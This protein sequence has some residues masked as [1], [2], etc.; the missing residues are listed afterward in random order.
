M[1]PLDIVYLTGLL[2]TMRQPNRSGAKTNSAYGANQVPIEQYL[3]PLPGESPNTAHANL[4]RKAPETAT[5]REKKRA[6]DR[7]YRLRCREKKMKTEQDVVVLT[8]ENNKLKRENEQLKREGV[9]QLEMVQTQKEEMKVVKNKLCPLKDQLQTQNALVK[10]FSSPVASRKNNMDLQCEN[11]RLRFQKSLLINKINDNDYL[12]PVQLQENYTELVQEKKALQPLSTMD[13][14]YLL[15]LHTLSMGGAA[16]QA[17]LLHKT[18]TMEG[19]TSNMWEMLPDIFSPADAGGL[20]ALLFMEPSPSPSAELVSN[21]FPK[22]TDANLKGATRYT[23]AQKKRLA[24]RA[25]RER[26]KELKMNTMNKLDEL[27]IEND[28]LRRENDS[29]KKEEVLLLQTLQRQKDEMKQLEK[30]FGQLKGQLNSQ[31]TVVEVLL[32]QLTG[33]NYEDPQ[34]ENTQLK[35]DINLL[36]KRIDNQENMNVTQLQAKIEQLENE[37]HSLQVIIDAL[38]EKITKDKDRLGPQELASQEEHVQMKRNCS[39]QKFED[40]GGPPPLAALQDVLNWDLMI[41][42]SCGLR[43]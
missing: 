4:K 33:S 11:K 12:N 37:K 31:N 21:Q 8:E 23:A 34:R 20:N 2:D 29:L 10:E 28:R 17:W 14:A 39:I 7:A 36:T 19:A 9:Q 32:K 22:T 35:H 3:S 5:Y 41:S 30:E 43:D 25:Y 6:I 1:D 15:Q 18:D 13:D 40:G 16:I 24:D 27:T 26:C 38:C 42:D